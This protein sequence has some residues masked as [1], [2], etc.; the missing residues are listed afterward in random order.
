ML[1]TVSED[2]FYN[3]FI[4]IERAENLNE[5]GYPRYGERQTKSTILLT[6]VVFGITI[7]L[8]MFFIFKLSA[9]QFDED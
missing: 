4:K 6:G 8:V 5:P 9:D 2:V 7:T 3:M 1:S